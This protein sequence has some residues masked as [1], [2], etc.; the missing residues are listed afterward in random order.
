MKTKTSLLILLTLL[1]LSA[2]KEK[3]TLEQRAVERWNAIISSDYEKAYEILSPAYRKNE[4][5]TS[6]M[7]R[8]DKVKTN[9]TWHKAE[10]KEKQCDGDVCQV[11]L[12]ITYT[13]QMPRRAYG[14]VENIPTTIKENWIKKDGEWYF[15]PKMK[16]AL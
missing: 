6:Y 11:D 9:L 10:F 12:T 8:I 5:L 15:V 1:S 2:C 16:A 13:Y 7:L 4:K 3:Q 14:K